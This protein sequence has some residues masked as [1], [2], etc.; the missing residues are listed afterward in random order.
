M[1]TALRAVGPGESAVMTSPMPAVKQL[2]PLNALVWP[3]EVQTRS[4]GRPPL[5]LMKSALRIDAVAA[6][7]QGVVLAVLGLE[8]AEPG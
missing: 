2:E 8:F 4:A 6:L 1:S 3:T 7:Q 5:S